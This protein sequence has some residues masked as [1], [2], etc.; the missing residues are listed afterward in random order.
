MIFGE[1][2]NGKS[3][4]GNSMIKHLLRNAR[5]KFSK[6]RAFVASKDTKAVTTKL[7]MKKFKELD[8]MDTPGFN[9]PDKSRTDTQL[10]I[11]MTYALHDR[12]I[13]EDGIAALLQCIMVP[14]SGRIGKTSIAL[15]SQM[16]Q[17]FTLSYPDQNSKVAPKILVL[18]TDF[19]K[20][21]TDDGDSGNLS[22][23]EEENPEEESKDP[24]DNTPG[25][26]TFKAL[27]TRFR[28]DLV[29]LLIED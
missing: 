15:M 4:T 18:F 25:K 27:V 1:M 2:G 21:E 7:H 8:I 22:Y 5:V 12:Y 26:I 14:T 10:F 11:D 17:L 3:T 29:N 28:E 6:E 24:Q 16:L 13:L 20:A 23:D 9:D 19:S